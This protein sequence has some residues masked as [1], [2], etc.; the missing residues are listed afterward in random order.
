MRQIKLTILVALAAALAAGAPAD[1]A[2]V[3]LVKGDRAVRVNDPFVPSKAE[4]ALGRPQRAAA[5]VASAGRLGAGAPR[6][7][8]RSRESALG[9]R[10]AQLRAPTAARSFARCAAAGSTRTTL[11]AG[12]AGTRD[13][14][15]PTAACEARGARSSAT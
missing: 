12:T 9:S 1:A 3:I 10:R 11:G 7:R 5:T 2:E 4:I 6:P 8:P 14:F 15:A 13:R